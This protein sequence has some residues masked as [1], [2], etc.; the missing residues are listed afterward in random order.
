MVQRV[1]IVGETSEC[2]EIFVDSDWAGLSADQEVHKWNAVCLKVW[3][4]TQTVIATSSG[5]AEYHAAVK[6]RG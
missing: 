5:E 4:R 2:L 3:S 6:G 1:P